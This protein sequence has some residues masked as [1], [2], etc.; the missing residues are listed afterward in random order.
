MKRRRRRVEEHVNHERW[1]IPYGDLIT[2]LL[3][4]FVV[5]YAMSAVNAAKY[6]EVSRSISAAFHG[7]PPAG[8]PPHRQTSVINPIPAVAAP[9]AP[10]PTSKAAPLPLSA[11]LVP[12]R[13]TPPAAPDLQQRNLDRI[14]QQVEKALQPLIDK[15]LVRLRRTPTWLEIEIRTDILF[16]SGV[17]ALT[18][19]ADKVLVQLGDILAPF[20]NPLRVEGYTDNK[21]INT[22]V[23]PSN[24]ELSAARA[25][26]VARLLAGHGVS[27]DRL[28][29]I[30]WGQFRP[31]VSNDTVDGRNRNRR[32]L[33]VV[34]SDH[35]GPSRFTRDA[36][37]MGRVADAA[38]ALGDASAAA[39][40]TPNT[41]ADAAA[42]GNA[43]GGVPRAAAPLSNQSNASP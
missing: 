20:G 9:A 26:S 28:G 41:V 15:K 37:R 18:G 16:P 21:A 14:Q 13:S 40:K 1:A 2:L 39:A 35:D 33:V 32:V 30:G 19:P 24:W 8:A 23:Y 17:A 6:R 7:T 5:M 27:P 4:L 10:R 31:V 12:K 3:A 11:D 25:A 43:R 22:V 42:D 34:L 38:G 29:I 36:E